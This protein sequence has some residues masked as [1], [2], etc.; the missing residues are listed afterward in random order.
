MHDL[1]SQTDS[2]PTR[3]QSQNQLSDKAEPPQEDDEIRF[4]FFQESNRK[5]L[6]HGKLFHLS[7][8]L[9]DTEKGKSIIKILNE[10]N[11]RYVYN[12]CDGVDF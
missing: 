8:E 7:T 6:C 11:G 9:Y 1:C 3:V 5:N 4:D 12:L 2:V 10:C